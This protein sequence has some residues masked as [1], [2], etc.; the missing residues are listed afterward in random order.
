MLVLIKGTPSIHASILGFIVLLLQINTGLSFN[1][2][3]DIVGKVYAIIDSL[4]DRPQ[5]P[6]FLK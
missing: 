3:L 5:S 4:V 1:L 6:L 2:F